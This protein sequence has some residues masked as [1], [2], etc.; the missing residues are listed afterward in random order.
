MGIEAKNSKKR[1]FRDTLK[2]IAYVKYVF[3]QSLT[4]EC[5]DVS[6]TKLFSVASI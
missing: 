4:R 1:V 5:K 2:Q 3:F 6:F